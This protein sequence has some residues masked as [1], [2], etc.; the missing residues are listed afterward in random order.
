MAAY[1]GAS[2]CSTRVIGAKFLVMTYTP[3]DFVDIILDKTGKY[4]KTEEFYREIIKTIQNEVKEYSIE[5][6]NYINLWI[7]CIRIQT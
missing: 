7:N 5:D 1:L 6:I 3:D 2:T 4:N